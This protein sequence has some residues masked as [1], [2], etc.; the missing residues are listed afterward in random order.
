[1]FFSLITSTI[2]DIAVRS[3]LRLFGDIIIGGAAAGVGALGSTF[4]SSLSG[5]LL[6]PWG[7]VIGVGVGLII[8]VG[9]FLFHWFRKSKRY[10]DWIEELKSKLESKLEEYK[11]TFSNDFKILRESIIEKMNIKAEILIKSFTSIDKTKWEELKNNY[12]IQKNIKKEKIK[13]KFN[14]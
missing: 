9:I 3:G 7:I 11:I 5:A 13:L 12:S 4:L 2:Y 6:G 10:K 8:S 14:N 1:M